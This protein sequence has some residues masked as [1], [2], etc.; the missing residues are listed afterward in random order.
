MATIILS[1]LGTAIGGPLGGTIGAM[2]G[3]QVDRAIF[4]PTGREGARLKEL[5][6]TNSSYGTPLGRH[7]GKMRT[8]G[9]IIWSTDLKE[10]REKSGGKGKP[11]VTTFSYSVSF[12]VA[13][14]SRPIVGLGRIWADGNL[15]RGIEGDLK[16]GGKLRL[17]NGHGDQRPDALLVAALGA[18]CPAH[19]GL[20]YCV[21]EDLQLAEFGNRIPA[22]AFEIFADDGE[23]SLAHLLASGSVEASAEGALPALL[24]FSDEGGPLAASL[25]TISE[26]YPLSYDSSG[27]QLAIKAA[28]LVPALIP[29]LP[30]AAADASGESFSSVTG[31]SRRR[32]AGNRNIPE[33][34]RYYDV[35]RDYQAGLQRADGRARSGRSR[36][37]EFPGVLEARHARKLANEAAARAASSSETTAWRLAELDSSLAPGA[38]V[39]LPRGKGLWRIENWEWRES[40][41]ELELQCLP[42]GR[43]RTQTGDA[44]AA[45]LQ[46]DLPISPTI[47]V[48]FEMPWDGLGSGAQR[49]VYAAASSSSSGWTG[50]AL[51]AENGTQLVPLAGTGRDRSLVGQLA[52]PLLAGDPALFARAASCEIDLSS[53][54]FDLSSATLEG[55]AMGANRAI[56]GDEIVQFSS[57]QRLSAT[58]WR[59]TGILRGEGG[60]E[61]AALLHHPIGTPF[62]LLD[63]APVALDAAV[64]GQSVSLAALGIADAEPVLAAIVGLG[65]T[66]RPLTPVHPRSA[67]LA[68]GSLSLSWTRRARGGWAWRDYVDVPLNEETERYLVGVGSVTAPVMH[69]ETPTPGLVLSSATTAT[70]QTNQPGQSLWVRQLGDHAASDPLLLHTLA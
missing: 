64:L 38:I 40:G 30:D 70:I 28:D 10:S 20:A 17:Y 61:A 67:M 24:G 13:L 62:V 29:M 53:A 7:F 68:D 37:I 18:R 1:A 27:K 15:L 47:L 45:V 31:E 16:V 60:S 58:R 8:S 46:P 34:I 33:G 66:L 11:S 21:L 42:H 65:R 23:V 39:K 14:S 54:D 59:I 4:K 44:G 63:G 57:A 9:S 55:L 19:R 12:A 35:A 51:Y 25:E 52:T 48:A 69:W 26:V 2:L 22:L 36:T 6:V 5:H 56:I 3:N 32:Q 41:V 49:H 50:A 43:I